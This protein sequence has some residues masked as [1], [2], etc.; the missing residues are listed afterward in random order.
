[1][2]ELEERQGHVLKILEWQSEVLGH[3]R[4]VVSHTCCW[5]TMTCGCSTDRPL[6]ALPMPGQRELSQVQAKPCKSKLFPGLSFPF[7][8]MRVQIP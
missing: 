1:M 3:L 6:P 4:P 5:P 8:E 7:C 2:W